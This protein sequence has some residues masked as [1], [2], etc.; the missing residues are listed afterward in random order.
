VVNRV[1]YNLPVGHFEVGPEDRQLAYYLGVPIDGLAE[2]R[3]I[4]ENMLGWA[5]DV[6][7]QE[8][9]RLMRAVY[10]GAEESD[11]APAEPGQDPR[12]FDA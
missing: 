3:A 7:D 2:V 6:V 1:N 5:L 4:F 11:L 10:A 12:R 8:H 9:P